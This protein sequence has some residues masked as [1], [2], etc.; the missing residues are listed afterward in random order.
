[1]PTLRE[2]GLTRPNFARMTPSPA[3]RNR[4]SIESFGL[5]GLK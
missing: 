2:G 4:I 5:K 1:M 3:M